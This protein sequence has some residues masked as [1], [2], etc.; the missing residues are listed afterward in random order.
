MALPAQLSEHGPA[1]ATSQI[2]PSLQEMLPLAPSV[3]A[4]LAFAPQSTLQESPHAPLQLASASHASVQL[5]PQVCVETAHDVDAAQVQLLPAQSGGGLELC[6]PQSTIAISDSIVTTP[7][8]NWGC[9]MIGRYRERAESGWHCGCDTRRRGERW[10]PRSN[11]GNRC[12]VTPRT[13]VT[14]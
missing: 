2:A 11:A 10:Q 3:T 7:K 13:R 14:G 9:F 12:A 8:T 4:Q 1:H 5:D 6:P